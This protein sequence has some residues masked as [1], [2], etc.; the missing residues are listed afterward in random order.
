MTSAYSIIGANAPSG[1]I[2]FVDIRSAYHAAEELW[3]PKIPTTET[4]P[5]LKAISD[6]SWVFW[7]RV[8]LQRPPKWRNLGKINYF[9]VHNIVN[10][11][12]EQLIEQSIKVY[13]VPDGQQRVT[14]L[15]KWPGLTFE[16]ESEAGQ[17]MLGKYYE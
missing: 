14:E 16:I 5:E 3:Y 7:N 9:V 12:T 8:Q 15:P 13:Y 6:V 2:F 1:V 17:A 11:E 10:K 4:L